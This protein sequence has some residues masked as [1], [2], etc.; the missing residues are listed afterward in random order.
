MW[1]VIIVPNENNEDSV[2]KRI[3]RV[4][5]RIFDINILKNRTKSYCENSF[6]GAVNSVGLTA[7]WVKLGIMSHMGD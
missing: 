6:T 1:C 3:L 4:W 5:K 2:C 7:G